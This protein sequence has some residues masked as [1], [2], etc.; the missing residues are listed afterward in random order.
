MEH[1][2]NIARI[3]FGGMTLVNYEVSRRGEQQI[4]SAFFYI[5]IMG[6]DLDQWLHFD[7]RTG[8]RIEDYINPMQAAN[9][10]P[11]KDTIKTEE[12]RKFMTGKLKLIVNQ[13][14]KEKEVKKLK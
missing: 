2:I 8:K 4:L 1:R 6:H 9:R 3:D 10:K 7:L 5:N 12:D 11:E 13:W 14:G